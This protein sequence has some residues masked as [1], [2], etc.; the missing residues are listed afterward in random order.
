MLFG[1]Y[2]QALEAASRT[3]SVERTS[4]K[5]EHNAKFKSNYPYPGRVSIQQSPHP[6]NI[7]LCSAS[8]VPSEECTPR[9]I[10]YTQRA[11]SYVSSLHHA[12][13]Q[14]HPRANAPSQEGEMR[15][16]GRNL[17]CTYLIWSH[18][19][20]MESTGQRLE[21]SRGRIEKAIPGGPTRSNERCSLAKSWWLKLLWTKVSNAETASWEAM[22]TMDK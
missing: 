11:T 7:T 14:H 3:I 15:G 1:H 20:T 5:V 13:R 4:T 6:A 8:D 18:W 17:L 9:E 10:L 16:L 21:S 22:T 19:L 12:A 2:I